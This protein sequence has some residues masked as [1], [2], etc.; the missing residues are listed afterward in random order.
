MK[1]TLNLSD[2]HWFCSPEYGSGLR[3]AN[4][5][6][7]WPL[8]LAGL[9]SILAYRSPQWR[10]WNKC[11]EID[12]HAWSRK[13][14][15]TCRYA[16]LDHCGSETK[17]RSINHISKNLN[18]VKHSLLPL[19]RLLKITKSCR[20]LVVSANFLASSLFSCSSRSILRSYADLNMQND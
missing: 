18:L 17:P 5:I 9:M 12:G 20:V 3:R 19:S 1:R 16:H 7:F 8:L 4:F 13:N 10:S 11:K 14:L 15:D 2:L 6:R